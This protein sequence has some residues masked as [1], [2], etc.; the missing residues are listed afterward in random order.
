MNCHEMA[1]VNYYDIPVITVIF[2]NG[3]LGMVR[4]W[5]TLTCKGRHSQTTLNR[6]PD[7]VMLAEAYGI[8]GYRATNQEEFAAAFQTTLDSGHAAV[9]DCVLDIDEM[10]HPMVNGGSPVT[11][12]LLD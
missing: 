4:Q 10:V 7:F 2:N 1:T 11:Q 12:F 9:I 5:Q 3:T 8:P 6:G